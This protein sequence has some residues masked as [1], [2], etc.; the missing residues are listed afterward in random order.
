[1]AANIISGNPLRQKMN[2]LRNHD[3]V[4]ADIVLEARK[5]LRIGGKVQNA[6]NGEPRRGRPLVTLQE[7]VKNFGSNDGPKVDDKLIPYPVRKTVKKWKSGLRKSIQTLKRRSSVT[8]EFDF[9]D[10]FELYDNP[11]EIELPQFGDGDAVFKKYYDLV[12]GQVGMTS[13]E[14][15]FFRFNFAIGAIISINAFVIAVETD[16][17]EAAI[18]DPV[19]F[20]LNNF[21]LIVLLAE[22]VLRIRWESFNQYL[23]STWNWLDILCASLGVADLWILS[24]F[25]GDDPA[26]NSE[27]PGAVVDGTVE[28][29]AIRGSGPNVR[30][31]TIL[32]VVRLFRLFRLLRVFSMFR[33]LNIII[34]AF[35][36][37]TKSMFWI[38]FLILIE[39]YLS[40][41]FLTTVVGHSAHFKALPVGDDGDTLEVFFG[42]L[43]ASMYTLFELLTLEGWPDL[44]RALIMEQPLFI[45]F[46]VGF[47]MTGTFGLLNMIVGMVVERT[48]DIAQNDPSKVRSQQKEAQIRKLEALYLLFRSANTTNDGILSWPQLFSA[49]EENQT[50]IGA[51]K[52]LKL[53]TGAI[54]PFFNYCDTTGDGKV[55]AEELI[56]GV[57]HLRG[58]GPRSRDAMT[59]HAAV[60]S[61]FSS[62]QKLEL[63]LRNFAM[64]RKTR[65]KHIL[66]MLMER[67]KQNDDPNSPT[68]PTERKSSS[69]SYV[70]SYKT[71]K[72]GF[73]SAVARAMEESDPKNVEKK[74]PDMKNKVL[75][76]KWHLVTQAT[77]KS[78]WV[79]PY[80]VLQ[81]M[82]KDEL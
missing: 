47:I 82:K 38:T 63:H 51:F 62:G 55:C 33:E 32:R 77:Q 50:T 76:R 72:K 4:V 2:D 11:N 6:K 28:P 58:M 5:S 79:H 39:I 75:Q 22:M 74:T 44:G 53:P 41:I 31:I 67:E 37:A 7:M 14:V 59:I 45:I 69:S 71:T 20:G 30:T 19:F 61:V 17:G 36:S 1:M 29:E 35:L 54:W 60:H 49:L 66:N 78:N 64:E 70:K 25:G 80:D 56:E 21:F 12:Q 26:P 57:D 15:F 43:G 65:Q 13:E 16:A 24:F 81:K 18:G 48:L 52:E 42:T 34:V 23:R 46:F 27:D 9:G 68:D 40:G 3:D 73:K 10:E 8:G